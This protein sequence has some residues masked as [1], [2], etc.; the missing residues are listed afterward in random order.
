MY[1]KK[2][3]RDDILQ[4]IAK[5]TEDIEKLI[6]SI[7]DKSKTITIPKRRHISLTQSNERH[8]IILLQGS[9]ELFR[10]SDGIV[11]NAENAPFI[12][13]ANIRL[14][15]SRHLYA[16]AKET[17]KL[18]LIPQMKFYETVEQYHLWQSLATLQDYTAAKVY[19]YCLT[20]SQLSAYE[21]IRSH[22]LDLMDE[23]TEL[24]INVTAASYIMDR[25]FLSRSGIMRILS[26][27]K[28]DG[29]IHLSRGV[30][31]DIVNLPAHLNMFHAKSK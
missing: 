23:P 27:L 31:M 10:V 12:F 3:L 18:L 26:K 22:L 14:S 21:I 30:L 2:T 7:V 16:R 6:Q 8:C 17:S 4:N 25:S 28:A 15:Y 9:V 13:G 19:A 5:P 24:R 1:S 29:Y 20:V 11:L